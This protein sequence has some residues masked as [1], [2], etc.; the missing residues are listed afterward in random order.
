MVRPTSYYRDVQSTRLRQTIVQWTDS[1]VLFVN[2][3]TSE[4]QQLEN[5]ISIFIPSSQV[6]GG[7]E[8]FI[9]TNAI[10]QRELN[11]S[12]T[13]NWSVETTK[14]EASSKTIEMAQ[15]IV[16][17]I[18]TVHIDNEHHDREQLIRVAISIC[19]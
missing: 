10:G 8:T 1:C 2:R 16:K 5:G 3:A 4:P 9:Y 11:N 12:F 18:I 6:R 14:R 15:Y 7:R 19:A 13:T 17:P